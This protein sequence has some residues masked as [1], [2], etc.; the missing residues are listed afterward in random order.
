MAEL[1]KSKLFVTGADGFI[2]SHLVSLLV[3]LG[4]DVTALSFYNSQGLNGWL[5]TLPE[6][7]IRSIRIVSGDIRDAG[8]MRTYI[9]GIDY[10]VHLAALIGIPYSYTAPHSYVSTNV[11]GTMNILDAARDAGTRQVIV[12][13]T[14]EVYGTAQIVPISEKHPLSAQSPYAASKIAADQLALSYYRSFGLPVS[15]LRPFNTYGPR[16]SIRA[17]I[18]TIILQLLR[19]TTEL[20]LGSLAPTR[21]LTFVEDTAYGFTA[22]L[23]ANDSIGQVINLGTGFEISISH[24]AEMIASIMGKEISIVA[25]RHRMRPAASEVERLLSD[26]RLAR[27]LLGWCPRTDGE[28]G[29]RAGLAHTIDWFRLPENVRWYG[30]DAYRI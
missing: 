12:T 24:L 6:E 19:G 14:S 27:S 29:L 11:I 18:P 23:G 1:A 3:R 21:D 8:L 16:Q 10:V 15:I 9:R 22:A 5:D 2:G 28:A 30:P 4:H 13:S 17:V 25:D 20:A 7:E 26:N